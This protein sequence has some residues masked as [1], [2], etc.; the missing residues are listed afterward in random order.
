MCFIRCIFEKTE[1]GGTEKGTYA[2]S[3]VVATARTDAEPLER[4][5]T[6]R[7]IL[8][9]NPRPRAFVRLY[10]RHSW[11]L[12]PKQP[13]NIGDKVRLLRGSEE[14]VITQFLKNNLIEVEIE[15]GFAIPV[16]RNE[17]VVV[18][19]EESNY[20]QPIES[21]REAPP[22]PSPR[23]LE[24]ARQVEG[25]YLAYV[26]I[27]DQ[28]LSLHLINTTDFAMPY[29][30]GEEANGNF[31]GV[32]SGT[33]ETNSTVKVSNLL[34]ADFDRWP[35]LIFQALYYRSGYYTLREPLMR[36][37]KHKAAPFFK[38]KATAPLLDKP[39]FLFSI[40]QAATSGG[41]PVGGKPL[42]PEKLKESMLAPKEDARAKD[43][44]KLTRPSAQVDLHIEELTDAYD[45]MN[46][47]DMLALQLQTFEEKL[48]QAIATGMDEITFVHGVG[49]GVLRREIQK[50]LSKMKN[51]MHFQD[52][53]R[54]KF[55]YGATL[56]RIK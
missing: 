13:L 46:N 47:G 45:S 51:I 15:D 27:N 21:A 30:L 36:R 23:D 50:R 9:A 26:P 24:K 5:E 29:V 11:R 12:K 43:Q 52:A 22:R 31:K 39:S 10:R 32:S 44:I 4:E 54:E 55:G 35:V 40:D 19:K 17:V 16:M 14:G 7:I 37:I 49:S 56:V 20:F 25:I 53:M 41:A 18:A 3:S 2:N 34:V 48:D 6:E 28:Q 33:I 8:S 38:S 42:D 1:D